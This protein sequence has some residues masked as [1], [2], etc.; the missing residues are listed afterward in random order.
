MSDTRLRS[1]ERRYNRGRSL[2]ALADLNVVRR[3]S[4]LPMI[5]RLRL[6][7]SPYLLVFDGSLSTYSRAIAFWG[8]YE[9]EVLSRF[10][11][12]TDGTTADWKDPEFRIVEA[13]IL[14]DPLAWEGDVAPIT[15][16]ALGSHATYVRVSSEV[17]ASTTELTLNLIAGRDHIYLP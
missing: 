5:V 1:A 10:V 9:E 2:E 6:N 11:D 12:K 17:T 14:V 15:V 13:D 16:V 8:R 4:G 7:L 3:R